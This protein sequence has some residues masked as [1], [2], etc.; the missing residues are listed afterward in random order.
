M[1]HSN[2][3]IM[4]IN[5][6]HTQKLVSKIAVVCFYNMHFKIPILDQLKE[7]GSERLR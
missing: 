3:K 1:T 4:E 2:D 7:A 6:E 5:S